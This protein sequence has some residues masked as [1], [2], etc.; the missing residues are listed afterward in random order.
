MGANVKTKVKRN[1]K[2]QKD[3]QSGEAPVLLRKVV[4]CLR[5]GKIFDC[6]RP[7]GEASRFLANGGLCT[8]CGSLVRLEWSDGS[9][10][11]GLGP[12][13]AAAE[14]SAE[15]AALRDRL[16]EFDRQSAKR[17]TVIDDQSDYF[18]IDS[19]AWL[20]DEERAELRRR[21]AEEEAAAEA[22]RRR[23]TVT[24]DLLGRRVIMDGAEEG[25]ASGS[26]GAAAVEAA[27]AATAAER[28]QGGGAA[29]KGPQA[30]LQEGSQG[31]QQ[32]RI[33]VCPS[34]AA[35]NYTFVGG[36]GKRRQGGREGGG[37]SAGAPGKWQAAPLT[38]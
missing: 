12:E 16:V 14:V 4:N 36:G 15:A 1:P 18:A 24:V 19:N 17:T 13:E 22:A 2:S 21:A 3:S 7:G 23:L 11:E 28:G 5:C 32:R 35:A 9:T 26:G 31:Q 38:A 37:A 25:V 27:M 29:A 30:A 8:F 33:S 20:D 34:M 10:N 6:R